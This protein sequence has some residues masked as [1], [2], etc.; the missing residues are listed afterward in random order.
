MTSGRLRSLHEGQT[1]ARAC[2]SRH[3]RRRL[4]RGAKVVDTT[5]DEIAVLMAEQEAISKAL[6]TPLPPDPVHA[7]LRHRALPDQDIRRPTRWTL[8]FW[9]SISVSVLLLGGRCIDRLRR[10]VG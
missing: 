5:R 9:A 6:V 2:R 4:C 7:H 1:R 10:L 8:R 3:R